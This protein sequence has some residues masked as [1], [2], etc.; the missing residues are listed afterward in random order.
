MAVKYNSPPNWPAPPPGWTPPKDWRPDPAWGPAPAGWQFWTDENEAT[1][2]TPAGSSSA[3]AGVPPTKPGNW[4]SRHKVLTGVLAGLALLLIGIG[5]GAGGG[6]DEVAA[7]TVADTSSPATPD[8]SSSE[9]APSPTKT[10]AAPPKESAEPKSLKYSGRGDK[11][12]KISKPADGANLIKLTHEGDSNFIVDQL[13]SDLDETENL[14]NEIGKY[15][16]TTILDVAEEEETKRLRIQADGKWTIVLSD[17]TTAR[18][19]DNSA[20]GRGDDV[21]IY[22]GGAGVAKLTHNGESNFIVEFYNE[23]GSENL[24]NE[25]GKYSGESVIGS[26]PGFLQL[27]ADGKWTVKVE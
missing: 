13:D 7:P 3:V 25:I 20:S 10:S 26:G 6:N 8:E 18:E 1:S 9:P 16:V 24:V 2:A 19:M 21:L 27:H 22:R 4:F 12:L 14:V 11:V 23:D 5:I 15:G 17:L